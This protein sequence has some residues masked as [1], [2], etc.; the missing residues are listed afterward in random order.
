MVL[1]PGAKGLIRRI[2]LLGKFACANATN[3]DKLVH[4]IAGRDM[5]ASA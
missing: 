2:G 3:H 5:K 1:P 4:D